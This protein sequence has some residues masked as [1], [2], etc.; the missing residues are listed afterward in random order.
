[1]K[2]RILVV[3]DEPDIC[4]ILSEIL[5]GEGYDVVIAQTPQEFCLQALSTA[6]HLIILDI[7]L[8][9]SLG[10]DVYSDLLFKGLNPATPVI[11][12][13]G[14]ITEEFN[15][16]DMLTSGRKYLMHAK[17]FKHDRLLRDIRKLTENLN[18]EAA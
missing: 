9:N 11:F 14:L 13:S 16:N 10:P 17:P 15:R 3:D 5:A 6:P 18:A 4:Q 7:N 12:L 1:M 8:G 2:I